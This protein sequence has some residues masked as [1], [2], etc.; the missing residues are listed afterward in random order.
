M[1]S[2]LMRAEEKGIT[3]IAFPLMGAGYYGIPNHVSARVMLQAIKS[4]LEGDSGL[5]EV[6]ICVFDTPQYESVQAAL[7]ALG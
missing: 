6:T 2:A 3:S 5:K 4:H 1:E 7:E